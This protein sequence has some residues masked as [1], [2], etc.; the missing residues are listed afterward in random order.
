VVHDLVDLLGGQRLG[1]E[2]QIVDRAGEA[3]I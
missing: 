3:A 1:I 2:P